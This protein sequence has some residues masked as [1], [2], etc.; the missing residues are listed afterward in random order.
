MNKTKL[1][2]INQNK[3]KYAIIG[4]AIIVLFNFMLAGKVFAS[5]ITPDNVIKLVNEQREK[6]GLL[7]LKEDS[8]LDT[9]AANKSK[10]MIA[11]D[12]FEHYAFG[13]SPWD[14]I[15]S[16]GYNYLYAGENLAMDF[17][18]AEGMVSSWMNSPAHRKNI[19]NPDYSDAGIGIVRGTYTDAT[20][21]RETTM[22]ANLF[23]REKPFILNV[24][25]TVI[26]KI[27]SFNVQNIF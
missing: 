21:V 12:Y 10:D 2:K 7:P 15:A 11:R 20:G 3:N 1:I 23:G 8:K 17:D 9:A 24:I 19:L 5:E 22:V 26:E 18:T 13:L 4:I 25:D 6:N 27:A 14:F 16:S